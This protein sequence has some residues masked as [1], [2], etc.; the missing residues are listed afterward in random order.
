[1][2]KVE[3]I[4]ESVLYESHLPAPLELGDADFYTLRSDCYGQPCVCVLGVFDGL[5]EG[6]QGLLA[7]AKKDAAA[8]NVPLVAVTFLPDPVEVLFDG[9]PRRWNMYSAF[10]ACCR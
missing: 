3:R 7:S 10:S 2:N 5:H 8:R 6:H 4:R 1:M 9:S